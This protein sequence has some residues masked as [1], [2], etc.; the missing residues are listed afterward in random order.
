[1]L[2]QGNPPHLCGTSYLLVEL[3]IY[4]PLII[5]HNSV[6]LPPH[7]EDV[8]SHFTHKHFYCLLAYMI[9]FSFKADIIFNTRL[10]KVLFTDPSARAG[11][12]TRSIFK[13][14]LTRLD[15]VDGWPLIGVKEEKIIIAFILFFKNFF[16]SFLLNGIA[17]RSFTIFCLSSAIAATWT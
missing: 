14:S 5:S 1:M 12:D 10:D 9:P 17:A 15:K 16:L 2:N 8:C 13:R 3:F 11:Y 6:I 7:T 4:W